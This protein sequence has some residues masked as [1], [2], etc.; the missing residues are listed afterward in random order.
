LALRVYVIPSIETEVHRALK[1]VADETAIKVFAENVSKLLLSAPFGPK[2]VLGVDPGIRT[3]CKLAIVDDSGKFIESSVIHLQSKNEQD[4]ARDLLR[5]LVTNRGIKA[6]AVGNGTAGRETE[7]FIR[8]SL[9]EF[10]ISVPVIMVNE[11]GAN[12]Y[13]TTSARPACRTS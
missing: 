1:D 2:A 11:S 5:D 12:I 8:E 3:G 4:Q 7:G 10:N 6:I 9:K 13:S